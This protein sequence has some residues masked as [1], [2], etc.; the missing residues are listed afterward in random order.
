MKLEHIVAL[1]VRLFAIA[2]ALYAIRDGASFIAMFLEQERQTA[3]YLFGAVMALLI[4]LAIVL[5]MFP[6]TVARGLVKFRE[7]GDVDIT[8]ASAQQIQVVGFTILG[9]YLLF[10]VVSD[11]FYWMV[12]WFVSQRA[13]E[14]PEL[15]L[16]QIARM[17]ATV[18]ELIFVLFLIFGAGGIARALRKFRYGNES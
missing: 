4:F 3:S 12:I 14:L 7:P 10:F 6:L 18:V 15:S 9:I 1:A 2:I 13:H 11:V 5:W 17:V 8:S 16:D